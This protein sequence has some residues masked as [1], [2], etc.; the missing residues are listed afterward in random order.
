MYCW[1]VDEGWATRW[2]LERRDGGIAHELVA[3]ADRVSR[4]CGAD[5]TIVIVVGSAMYAYHHVLASV[6]VALVRHARYPILVV[7]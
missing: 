7:P 1:A 2:R 4:D 5:A 6:P 3:A